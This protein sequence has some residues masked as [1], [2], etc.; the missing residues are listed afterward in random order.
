MNLALRDFDRIAHALRQGRNASQPEVADPIVLTQWEHQH[1]VT[2][3]E[4]A[5]SLVG[6]GIAGRLD[7]ARFLDVCGAA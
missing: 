6:I 7:P 3:L 5:R 1:R 4:V 2:C